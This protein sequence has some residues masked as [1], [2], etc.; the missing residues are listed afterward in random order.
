MR[1]TPILIVG[2]LLIG[3]AGQAAA[4]RGRS[5][6]AG[7]GAI[8]VIVDGEVRR[9][10]T[11][12]ELMERRV[13][14]PNL[15]GKFRPTVALTDVLPFDALGV[16]RERVAEVSIQGQAPGGLRLTGAALGYLGELL[17]QVDVDKGGVW[18]LVPRTREA[19]AAL[20]RLVGARR[21]VIQ[22]VRRIE[23]TTGPAS[24]VPKS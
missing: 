23:V 9:A 8:Q 19:E 24:P 13:D 21:I 5:W 4:Q 11:T 22:D 7:P 14:A 12:A 1:G 20:G 6:D 2:L 3:V 10:W 18:K 16:S 15:R 17:L